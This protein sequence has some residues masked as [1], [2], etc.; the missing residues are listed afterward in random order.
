MTP[1]LDPRFLRQTQFDSAAPAGTAVVVHRFERE[2]ELQLLV[3]RG[4]T[5]L[6]RARINVRP[7]AGDDRPAASAPDLGGP[8]AAPPAAAAL[9]LATLLRPGVQAPDPTDLARGGYLSITSS[10]PLPEHHVV[11]TAGDEVV[12]DTRRL[13]PQSVFAVTLVRPGRYRL[14]N[15]VTGHEA[16]V[17]VTYP[18]VGRARYRPPDP[19]EIE[20]GAKG[21]GATSFKISP[22]QGIIFRLATE[23][24]IQ[25]EL[26]EP[27]DGP[28][29]RRPRPKASF[30]RPAPPPAS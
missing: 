2:G 25:L 23:S 24:R 28:A 30:R 11:V 9:D 27:D 17:V 20:C 16:A 8:R 1:I 12:L 14:A 19:V 22:A 13:G 3:H 6:R 10:E 15:A 29:A 4:K 5:P 7:E 26:V 21:F 18:E